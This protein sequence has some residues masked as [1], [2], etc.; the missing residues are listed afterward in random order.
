MVTS[1]TMT[2]EKNQNGIINDINDHRVRSA[3]SCQND[4]CAPEHI[5]THMS[6]MLLR[7]GN[8]RTA[9][10]KNR[11]WCFPVTPASQMTWAVQGSVNELRSRVLRQT[12]H[13]RGSKTQTICNNLLLR[14]TYWPLFPAER[15][16]LPKKLYCCTI[17]PSESYLGVVLNDTTFRCCRALKR[18]KSIHEAPFTFRL[19][20]ITI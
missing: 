9:Q 3:G 13:C 8:P 14:L 15:G 4:A 6:L 11:H 16:H 12:S 20:W 17:H 5:W 7:I 1:Y 18:A 2:G 10:G 19:A